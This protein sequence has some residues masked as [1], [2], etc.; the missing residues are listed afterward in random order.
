M[1]TSTVKWGIKLLAIMELALFMFLY[2]DASYHELHHPVGNRPP[3][4]KVCLE[5][6]GGSTT[7]LVA[8]DD[9]FYTDP[10]V[11]Q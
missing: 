3:A 1:K 11:N 10:L 2:A 8:M 6:P 5:E 7:D 9:L 4:C